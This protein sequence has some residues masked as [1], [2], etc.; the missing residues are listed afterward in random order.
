MKLRTDLG[1]RRWRSSRRQ[2]EQKYAAII[3]IDIFLTAIYALQN[4]KYILMLIHFFSVCSS[5]AGPKS[6]LKLWEPGTPL[7]LAQARVKQIN[8]LKYSIHFTIPDLAKDPIEGSVKVEFNLKKLN[9][10]VVF[11]FKESGPALIKAVKINNQVGRP[12]FQAGHLYISPEHLVKGSNSISIDFTAGSAGFQRRNDLVYTLFVPDKASSAFPCFDQPDLKA[13]YELT[14]GLP[15][16]WDAVSQGMIQTLSTKD[17]NTIQFSESLAT[18]PYLFAFAAGRFEIVKRKIDGRT[19]RMFH[20]ESDATKVERNLDA[21]FNLHT[22]ALAWL[23]TYTEIPYPFEKFDFVVI[24]AFPFGGMEH[25]GSIFYTDKSLFLDE[26]ASQKQYLDR[27]HLIAH[28]TTHMWFGDLVTMRWFDDVWLKEVFANFMADKIVAPLFPSIN[29]E[30]DFFLKHYPSAYSVERTAGTNPIQQELKNLNAASSLYGAIIYDKAP[31]AMRQLERLVGEKAFQSGLR[32]YLAKFKFKNAACKDLISILEK[33]SSRSLQQWNRSWIQ[34]SGRPEIKV[35]NSTPGAH[36]IYVISSSDTEHHRRVWPQTIELVFGNCNPSQQSVVLTEQQHSAKLLFS[37]KCDPSYILP[38][39]KDPGYCFFRLDK[40]TLAFLLEHLE[41]LENEGL[42][43]VAW[44]NLWENLVDRQISTEQ[45]VE[46]SIRALPRETK[47]Q[48]VDFVLNSLKHGYWA[49]LNESQRA[50]FSLPLEKMLWSQANLEGADVL[51][52]TSY[53]N[54]YQALF[55]SSEAWANLYA[56]WRGEEKI[57]DISL[58][59]TDLMEMTYALALRRPS[60]ARKIAAQQLAL[61][62]DLE[63]KREFQFIIEA[64]A[65]TEQERD[66]F[67]KTLMTAENR[68]NEPWVLSAL[69]YLHHPLHGPGSVKY[70][71]KSLELLQEI[72]DSSGI[73]F[74]TSWVKSTLRFHIDEPSRRILDNFNRAHQDLDPALKRK[75]LQGADALIRFTSGEQK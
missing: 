31:I 42:R 48:T 26:S 70:V 20:R 67:F 8:S 40:K 69:Y 4:M 23:G 49:L 61:I 30:V 72:K 43:A 14:L 51:V 71:Q 6:Q 34:Q 41:S 46:L 55:N 58:A 2:P 27:A 15:K 7:K 66:A 33:H 28:E 11:D 60:E 54:A 38:L 47:S 19:I 18:S 50:K 13:R 53:L 73:F 35:Q 65:G 25:P 52:R 45:F 1:N 10:P 32:E 62:K 63:R 5:F 29:S 12:N 37:G 17:S 44:V 68:N 24:P 39:A 64:A 21:I 75:L 57:K 16:G 56:V 3:F 9:D 59:E 22:K 74:P 36:S